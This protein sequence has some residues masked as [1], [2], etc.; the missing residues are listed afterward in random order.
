[1]FLLLNIAS[2]SLLLAV[3]PESL[4]V[5]VFGIGLVLLAIGLRWFMKRNAK[6]TDREIEKS[7]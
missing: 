6:N 4:G 7:R 3:V 1:M 2:R 5:L